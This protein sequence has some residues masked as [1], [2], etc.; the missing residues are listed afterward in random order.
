MTGQKLANYSLYQVDFSAQSCGKTF[1]PTKRIIKFRFGFA[2][3]AA[4]EHGCVGVDCRGEEHEIICIWSV[5]SGKQ[6]I[7]VDGEET[8]RFVPKTGGSQVKIECDFNFGKHHLMKMIAHVSKP[9]VPI[10]H[11]NGSEQRQFDLFL[12]GCSFFEFDKLF[13]LGQKNANGRN[14]NIIFSSAPA[15]NNTICSSVVPPTDNSIFF[16]GRQVGCPALH[17]PIF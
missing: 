5:T 3:Q 1:A 6:T 2:N 15:T 13:E 12:D 14:N 10:H 9:V 8:Y 11:L 4:L 17:V 16:H 7:L